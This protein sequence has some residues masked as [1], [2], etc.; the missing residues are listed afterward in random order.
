MSL[1]FYY[2]FQATLPLAVAFSP[3]GF[4]IFC[5]AVGA[6]QTGNWILSPSIV[7]DVSTLLTSRRIFG[8]IRNLYE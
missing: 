6:M 7:V 5:M 4:A 2:K 1:H 8:L 3:S